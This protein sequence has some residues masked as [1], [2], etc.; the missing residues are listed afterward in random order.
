MSDN[1]FKPQRPTGDDSSNIPQGSPLAGGG[2]VAPESIQLQGNIPAELLKRLNNN[3]SGKAEEQ[4]FNF[5]AQKFTN[6][7]ASS[8]YAGNPDLQKILA[9][10]KEGNDI[11]E[12]IELPSK[13]RFYDGT[14]GPTDGK[15]HI[16]PMTGEEEQ[17]L[18]TPRFVRKGVAI[19]MIFSRCIKE[20]FKPE[21]F[22]SVDRTFLLIYLRGISY[23]A[24]YEVEVKDPE[25][26]RKFT[27]VIDLD[28]LPKENCPD[29]FGPPLQDVLPKSGLPFTY[30]LSRGKDEVELQDYRDRRLKQFGDTATD[31]TLIFR[32]AQLVETI[33][34]ITNKTEIQQILRNLPIQDLSFLRGVVNEPPF[35]VDTKVTMLSPMSQEEFEVDLPLEA[36]FFFPK[37]KR[38]EKTL[39]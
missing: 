15:L 17:I 36:N 26:D 20:S 8:V 35:G 22:L 9:T 16:R 28:S 10:L 32:S 30:R 34:S 19:N 13:G 25:T 5:P 24:E 11:Y 2:S 3:N 7:P 18:A 14:D 29:D 37:R 1:V 31:D 4:P 23:G 27:T 39:A 6:S 33:A 12:E 21:N 38:K